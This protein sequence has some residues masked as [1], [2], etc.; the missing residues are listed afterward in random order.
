LSIV[1]VDGSVGHEDQSGSGVGNTGEAAGGV[2]GGSDFVGGGC[3]FPEAVGGGD[4]SVGDSA[5]V[6]R[7]VSVAEVVGAIGL[8]GEVGSEE[9]GV[10][11]GFGVVEEGG[12]LAGRDCF[13]LVIWGL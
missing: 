5:G 12:L 4:G 3:E 1:G 7:G 6:F 11:G 8:V 10:E 13:V 2:D 9:G